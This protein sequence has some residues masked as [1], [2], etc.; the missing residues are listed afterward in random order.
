MFLTPLVC[1]LNSEDHHMSSHFV[2]IKREAY[3]GLTHFNFPV[4]FDCWEDT[5]LVRL[6][7]FDELDEDEVV[8]RIDEVRRMITHDEG[9]EN[10][11][12]AK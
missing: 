4:C 1:T 8:Q 9:G 10:T 2:R 6:P 12:T 5:M 11:S 7:E 3:R